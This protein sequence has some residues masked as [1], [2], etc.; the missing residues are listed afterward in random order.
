MLADSFQ[1]T[2]SHLQ[3]TLI[4]STAFTGMPLTG[5]KNKTAYRKQLP[6][7]RKGRGPAGTE[8]AMIVFDINNLKI[9]NDTLGHDFGDIPSLI[10][11][12]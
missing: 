9:I 5:V 3:N 10:P 11:V 8:F 7:W 4:T 12:S 1:Q 2:V 6:T